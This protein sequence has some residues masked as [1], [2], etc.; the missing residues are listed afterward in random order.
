MILS[1]SCAMTRSTTQNISGCIVSMIPASRLNKKMIFVISDPV[2]SGILHFQIVNHDS[3]IR[4]LSFN[5]VTG[6]HSIT[7]FIPKTVDK[8]SFD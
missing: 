5:N 3:Y 2:N 8:L 4:L 7:C 6:R 1:N